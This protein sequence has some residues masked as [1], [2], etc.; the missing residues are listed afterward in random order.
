MTQEQ[1][2]KAIADIRNKLTPALTLCQII[3]VE[4]LQSV[5]ALNVVELAKTG[6][7]SIK[8]ICTVLDHIGAEL[9]LKNQSIK[10]I[11][12]LPEKGINVL[13]WCVGNEH[14]FIGESEKLYHRYGAELYPYWQ[15]L[16]TP[17]ESK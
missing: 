15:P 12:Q 13:I 1:I 3:Q 16:P 2:K 4:K 7:E 5:S 17:T 10:T 14:W 9:A 8:H 6:D 11:E